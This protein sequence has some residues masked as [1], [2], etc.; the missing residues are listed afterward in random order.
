M[1]ELVIGG[2]LFGVAYLLSNQDPPE[3]MAN[4][5]TTAVTAFK[6]NQLKSKLN[7][8]HTNSSTS[9]QKH[10][11]VSDVQMTHNNM[12]PYYKN[13]SIDDTNKHKNEYQRS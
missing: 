6:N 5:E 4:I 9:Q 7:M 13:K 12:T 1:S 2:V 10:M 3:G 11:T 8:K